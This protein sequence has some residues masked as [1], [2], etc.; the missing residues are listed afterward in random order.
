M[1]WPWALSARAVAAARPAS[2]AGRGYWLAGNGCT[3]RVGSP[4]PTR[5]T[6]L[7][8]A[9]RTTLVVNVAP[10][11]SAASAAAEVTSLAVEAGVESWSAFR[12]QRTLPVAGSA[13]TAAT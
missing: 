13:T 9:P 10:G 7:S 11:P 5:V 12:D 3:A 2:V 8:V 1:L 6:L 4:P